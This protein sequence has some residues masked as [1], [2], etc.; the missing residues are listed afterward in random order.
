MQPERMTIPPDEAQFLE[1]RKFQAIEI[2]RWFGVP[3]HKVF[4]L[5]RATWNNIEHQELEFVSDAVQPIVT[6]LEQEADLKLFGRINR[7]VLYTKL[8][9]AALLRGDMKSRYEA[10]EIAHRNG[11]LNADEIRAREDMNPLPKGQGKIYVLQAQMVTR[12]DVKAGKQLKSNTPAPES[13][14]DPPDP[15]EEMVA[16]SQRM[17]NLARSLK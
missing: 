10:Y 5:E 7:G 12:E 16:R 11:W 6:Q 8:N 14:D 1:S 4:A 2:C 3:P 15:G 9:M 17:V 13:E